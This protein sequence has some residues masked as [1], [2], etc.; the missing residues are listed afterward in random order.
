MS[1]SSALRDFLV[2][3]SVTG[4]ASIAEGW[5]ILMPKCCSHPGFEGSGQCEGCPLSKKDSEVDSHCVVCL[6]AATQDFP[7][8]RN[9]CSQK[10]LTRE[11]LYKQW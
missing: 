2:Y 11:I 4:Q 10:S 1:L 7:Y 5:E 3:L 6:E 9:I 8:P